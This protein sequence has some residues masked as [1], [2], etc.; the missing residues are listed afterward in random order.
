MLD[1]LEREAAADLRTGISVVL[2]VRD[3]E[4]HLPYAL[5]SVASWAAD[6]VVVDMAS[7]D[8]TVRIA[9]SLGARVFPH[10]RL[11]WVEPARAF[12]I[13]QAR[14]PWILLLDADELV[15]EPLSRRL[16]ELA[17]H[18]EADVVRLPRVNYLLGGPLLSTGWNPSREMHA[19]FFRRG[20]VLIP[21]RLH[22]PFRPRPGMR[23]LDL[24]YVE[25]E[26]LVHFNYVDV[27]HFVAKLD[28][29]TTLEAE[30]ALARGERSSGRRALAEALRE[31]AAR[32]L[33]HGGFRDGW[34]GFY[35]ALL[36]AFYRITVQA[37]MASR[38]RLGSAADVDR[39]Y[40][41]E[42]ERLL[43]EYRT[44]VG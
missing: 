26:A 40:A 39:S 1:C 21:D 9:E 10:E 33:R 16:R 6:V 17:R 36:M 43:A 15:P 11:A 3:E 8:A 44:P 31:W 23:S 34:R 28:R 24:P 22:Q 5:R 27:D 32:Y 13:A 2:N 35:L 41:R 7:T 42:A 38:E 25:G 30:H 14:C 29:Y 18:G 37:K 20:A 12:A 19:R 4:R